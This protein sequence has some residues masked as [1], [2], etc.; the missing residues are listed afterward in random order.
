MVPESFLPGVACDL[1]RHGVPLVDSPFLVD[2]EDRRVGR[3]DEEFQFRERSLNF[4][5][6]TLRQFPLLCGETSS[7]VQAEEKHHHNQPDG[8]GFSDNIDRLAEVD[9]RL[10]AVEVGKSAQ[11]DC[12]NHQSKQAQKYAISVKDE[13]SE[14]CKNTQQ[15]AYPCE[16]GSM[17]RRCGVRAKYAEENHRFRPKL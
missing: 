5:T 7:P 6:L 17:E 9:F 10:E 13:R 16:A 3:L 12:E 11:A 1:G 2:S 4:P 8:R 14:C 15:R